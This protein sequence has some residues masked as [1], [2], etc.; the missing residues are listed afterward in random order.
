MLGWTTKKQPADRHHLLQYWWI[1]RISKQILTF[2][3]NWCLIIPHLWSMK[4]LLN[5][6]KDMCRL[7]NTSI[8]TFSTVGKQIL[9]IL[10][11]GLGLSKAMFI[12][13]GWKTVVTP[14]FQKLNF[15]VITL[16]EKCSSVKDVDEM[17]ILRNTLFLII[18][19]NTF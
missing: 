7:I 5:S 17:I 6:L 12:C 3:Y 1:N 19:S 16:V 11:N 8:F 14:Y 2:F 13:R 15:T 4:R 18:W 9:E 10:R